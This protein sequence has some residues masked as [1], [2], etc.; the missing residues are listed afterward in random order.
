[1]AYAAGSTSSVSSM[2]DHRPPTT[3]AA[4][5]ADIC[6]NPASQSGGSRPS[7]VVATVMISGAREPPHRADAT[8]PST[9]ASRA[10]KSKVKRQ[11]SK[12]SRRRPACRAPR[13]SGFV[14]DVSQLTASVQ[15]LA[16]WND[17]TPQDVVRQRW[18][19]PTR[20]A[21]IGEA[22]GPLRR[23]RRRRR[24]GRRRARSG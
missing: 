2:H 20:R 13:V 21:P 18:A 19:C 8:A 14:A 4:V 6:A 3:G 15:R 1:M 22:G 9:H 24:V 10:V 7:T 12:A 5:R 23:A 17:P 11:G 16:C